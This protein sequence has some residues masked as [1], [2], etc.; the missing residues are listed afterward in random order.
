MTEKDRKMNELIDQL[1]DALTLDTPKISQAE[2][3]AEQIYELGY[4]E[5]YRDGRDE[6]LLDEASRL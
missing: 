5:G 6:T 4:D 3:I 1:I 2:W